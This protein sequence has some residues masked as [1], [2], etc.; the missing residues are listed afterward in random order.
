MGTP[1]DPAKKNS[2]LEPNNSIFFSLCFYTR[3][4]LAGPG[5]LWG[6]DGSNPSPPVPGRAHSVREEWENRAHVMGTLRAMNGGDAPFINA[7]SAQALGI[8]GWSCSSLRQ[9][10]PLNSL[11]MLVW[12]ELRECRAGIAARD[13]P[14]TG[15]G[16]CRL[17]LTQLCSS[18]VCSAQMD[19]AP[20][21]GGGFSCHL[22]IPLPSLGF[23][24][25]PWFAWVVITDVVFL[26]GM[27]EAP[28]SDNPVRNG[29][30]INYCRQ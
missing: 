29:C 4:F 22:T 21:S 26:E 25:L 23:S 7:G 12:S 9:R 6:G 19:G 10:I 24:W 15:V 28:S 1:Q 11:L 3:R 13:A 20:E 17:C 30:L 14:G 2:L 5:E 8:P 18:G 16:N 27:G